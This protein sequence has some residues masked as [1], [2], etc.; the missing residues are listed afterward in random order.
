V[1]TNDSELY[2]KWGQCLASTDDLVD[3][4][5]EDGRDEGETNFSAVFPFVVVP[6]GRLWIT[7]YDEDGDRTSEPHPQERCSCY[8]GKGYSTGGIQFPEPVTLSHLEI[9]T[10]SGLYTFV[11][12]YLSNEA[13]ITAV[14]PGAGIN[15]AVEQLANG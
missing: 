2:E 8:I 7:M 1:V 14:F 9:V 12:R 11:D 3:E 15:V 10:Q 6:D 4:I 13:R 5:Y